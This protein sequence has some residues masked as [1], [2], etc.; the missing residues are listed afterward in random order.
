MFKWILTDNKFNVFW[1][2]KLD[3]NQLNLIEDGATKIV[4]YIFG[5]D[6]ILWLW[7]QRSKATA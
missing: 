2:E 3:E 6:L 5:P 1:L 4:S 7:P